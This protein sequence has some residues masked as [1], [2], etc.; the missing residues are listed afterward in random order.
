MGEI[1][2]FMHRNGS[3]AP[4][5]CEASIESEAYTDG[6][7]ERNRWPPEMEESQYADL[8]GCIPGDCMSAPSIHGGEHLI[9]RRKDELDSGTTRDRPWQPA[10]CLR[11]SPIR[12]PCWTRTTFMQAC[13]NFGASNFHL[14]HVPP[15][16]CLEHIS[17]RA[18][19]LLGSP[20]RA[21]N[22]RHGSAWLY[23]KSSVFPCLRVIQKEVQW[24][25]QMPTERIHWLIVHLSGEPLL[26]CHSSACESRSNAV[27]RVYVTS[28]HLFSAIVLPSP[29]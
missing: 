5:V 16:G 27:S 28:R 22:H 15:L 21:M 23:H 26:P 2:S 14:P 7:D 10:C 25:S 11:F 13:L 17:I 19:A 8:D 24:S 1:Q 12:N 6:H 3:I 9:R 4:H 20:L 29:P 18:A